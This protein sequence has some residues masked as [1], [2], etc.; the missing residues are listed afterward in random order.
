M[1]SYEAFAQ[2]AKKSVRP[3]RLLLYHAHCD[4]IEIDALQAWSAIID[5]CGGMATATMGAGR[6]RRCLDGFRLR[7]SDR[8]VPDPR[9]GSRRVADKER[10]IGGAAAAGR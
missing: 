2:L 3:R 7:R 8:A 6:R 4:L 1:R 10:H 5:H 9:L